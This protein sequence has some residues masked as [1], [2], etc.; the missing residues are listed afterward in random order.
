MSTTADCKVHD[1][2]MRKSSHIYEWA[3]EE[4]Y[5]QTGEE[6]IDKTLSLCVASKCLSNMKPKV[7]L[8]SVHTTLLVNNFPFVYGN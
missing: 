6:A 5:Y 7:L 2:N 8:H 1:A 4:D 3:E